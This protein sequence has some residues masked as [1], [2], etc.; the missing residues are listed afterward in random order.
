MLKTSHDNGQHG[1]IRKVDVQVH[2]DGSKELDAGLRPLDHYKQVTIPSFPAHTAFADTNSY[3]DWDTNFQFD[4]R[5]SL[6]YAGKPLILPP[7]R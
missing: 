1:E 5:Y 7:F 4:N 2:D 6:L 3:S